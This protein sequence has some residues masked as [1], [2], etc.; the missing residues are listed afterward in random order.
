MGQ[1]QVRL[2]QNNSDLPVVISRH[3]MAATSALGTILLLGWLFKYIHYGID[4]T[5]ESFY[6]V[7]MSNPFIYPTSATQ[8]GFIYHPLYIALGGDIASIRWA[9][10]LLTF[11]LGWILIYSFLRYIAPDVSNRRLQLHAAA[12]GL[13]TSSLVFL[14]TWLPTPSY[15][16]LAFQA[17]MLTATGLLWADRTVT[18]RSLFGWITIGVGGWLTLM[19]KPS[20]AALLAIGIL[21]CLL[22]S[23][24]F[25]LRLSLLAMA[26]ALGLLL[27]SAI[28]IDGSI[29]GFA[30]RLLLGIEAGKTLGGGHTAEHILRIDR[31]RLHT[32]AKLAI[33]LV[34]VPS[35]LATCG[36]M[37]NKPKGMLLSWIPSIGFFLATALMVSGA[38]QR[39]LEIGQ[40]EGILILGVS[41]SA[42]FSGL[43]LV[44]ASPLKSIPASHWVVAALFVVTPYM[45]AFGTNRNYWENGVWAGLF[46]L[47]AG[48]TLMGPVI[49][50]RS[51]WA[52]LLPLAL[53]TQATTAILV[54]TGLEHPQRQDQPLS[55]NDT[56]AEIRAQRSTLVLSKGYATYIS[57]AKKLA[58]DGGFLAETP[59]I[60]LSGQ[61]PGILFALGAESIGQAWTIGGYPGSL[62]LTKAALDQVSCEKIATAWVLF[63]PDGPRRIPT[64]IMSSLG[65][66]FPTG[67]AKVGTWRTAEGAGG[68]AASRTQELYQPIAPTDTLRTCQALRAET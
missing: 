26:T 9:N 67:Y 3:A 23:R 44:K 40:V 68:Y 53:A 5:D 6:L 56:V 4:F 14:N 11:G 31:L 15:N 25:S 21:L 36:A 2:S 8:F 22:A 32:P 58:R 59:M 63:E 46:W 64:E 10:I 28:L 49:R 65:S 57:Q 51:S 7:W 24:K 35:L 52:I 39:T 30:R 60:D 29:V 43:L 37:S 27:L 12:A 17:L 41:F 50:E 33:L 62:N 38:I 1:W 55:L 42:V 48:L 16:S 66:T 45:Y 19:A 13:A 34:F 61:S 18:P 20:T 54:H 47:L